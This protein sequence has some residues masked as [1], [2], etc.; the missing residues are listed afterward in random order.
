[1]FKKNNLITVISSYF[2]LFNC[3]KTKL[4]GLEATSYFEMECT[5]WSAKTKIFTLFLKFILS[6]RSPNVTN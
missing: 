2:T 3:I 5:A 4:V 1:M 6:P